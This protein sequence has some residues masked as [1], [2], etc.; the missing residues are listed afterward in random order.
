MQ[1]GEETKQVGKMEI[2]KKEKS[3]GSAVLVQAIFFLML[4]KLE[5]LEFHWLG[6]TELGHLIKA[7]GIKLFHIKLSGF[8]GFQPKASC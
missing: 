6:I 8:L 4:G 5:L 7:M 2:K 1:T 3:A